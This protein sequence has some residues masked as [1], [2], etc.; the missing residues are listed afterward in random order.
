[1]ADRTLGFKVTDEVHD[2]AKILIEA[3]GLT[4]KEWIENAL[5]M[6]EVKVLQANTP[7]YAK[8]LTELELHTT[9][10]Y[11]LVV[12]MIQQSIY[13]KDHAVKDVADKLESKEGIITELQAKLME[14]KEKVN[15]LI[16]ENEQFTEQQKLLQKQIDEQKSTIDNSNLLIN[17][18]KEKNDTLSGL[19]TKYQGYAEENETLKIDFE[20]K[21][22]ELMQQLNEQQE[23]STELIRKLEQAQDHA[24]ERARELEKNLENAH[25][26]FTR[27]L[28]IMQERKDLE[29]EKALVEVE[30]EYQAKLQ[31]QNDKYN[32]KV[33]EM[34]A[35]NERIRENYEAKLDAIEKNKPKQ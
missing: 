15:Q 10:I 24:N 31:A 30:R 20:A 13:L 7:E 21:K 9:R 8:D 18:Y 14:Q 6:Y 35:E 19:V 17:E 16:F 25:L 22:A 34:H 12:N 32:D 33:A 1:M 29:R 4:S 11:E 23:A 5:A 28:E 26:N 27:E 3:S 2:K